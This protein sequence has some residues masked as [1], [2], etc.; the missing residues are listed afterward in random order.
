[1]TPKERIMNTSLLLLVPP[2]IVALGWAIYHFPIGKVGGGMITLAIV[3]VFFSAFLRIEIPRT[4]LHLT[5]SDAL[6]FLSMLFYGGGVAIILAM[7]EAGVSS[8][9]LSAGG[10]KARSVTKRTILANVLIAGFSTFSTAFVVETLFGHEEAILLGG[11]NTMLAYLLAVMALA[12][13]STNTFLASAYVAMRNDRK[14]LDVWN[15]QCF[16]SL[17]LFSTGALM[18][19][20]GAKAVMQTDMVQFALVAGFFGLVY[21]TF[22]RYSDDVRTV[23]SEVERSEVARAAEAD[24]HIAELNHFVEELKKTADELTESRESF[25]H[26]AYH[27]LLT[28]L[29]NRSYV[30]ELIDQLLANSG[31]Q[32]ASRFAVL[33]LN[34]DRFRT[35]NESLGY[36]TGDRV[37][38]YVASKLS[39]MARAGEIVGHFGGD[40]FTVILPGIADEAAATAF[41]EKIG[42]TLGEAIRFKGRQV[43][44]SVSIGVVFNGPAH[45]K[46]EDILRDADI[47]MYN[48]K[49]NNKGS[50]VFDKTMHSRA[51]S[52]QKIESDLRYA[53]V[54]N[55]LEMYYQPIVDLETMDLAGFEALV[56]WNHP[57]KGMVF[58]SEFIPVSEDTGL[59]IPMTLQAL[60]SSCGQIVEWQ[61]ASHLN[62][63]LTVSV[64]LSGKHF[65]DPG[66]VDQI[67]KIVKES[68]IAPETLKLEITES[69]AMEDAEKAIEKLNEI[70]KLGVKLSMDDFG[71]GYSSLSY[72]RRFPVD[73]LKIDRSFVSGMDESRQNDE[74]VQT[75]M[76]L[77]KAVKLDVVAEGIETA[78]QLGHLRRLGCE[79][80]QGYLFSRPVPAL[81]VEEMLEDRT[82]WHNLLLE[83]G[84]QA[85]R[86]ESDYSRSEFTN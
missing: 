68:G 8:M 65:A 44:T 13:F 11:N 25:R 24:A 6:V 67:K 7:L 23:S 66:L 27:Q 14:L 30:I 42:T 2:G 9:R 43:Y 76:A 45:K 12:Q 55:E 4:K 33:L 40:Q 53:I 52:R 18:A 37:I 56:R 20:L 31:G 63:Y 77:A 58:P 86:Q 41:A 35:I 83:P 59:I 60:R 19:G 5:I 73:T 34:L 51:V 62:K 3:T 46:G 85:E 49:D 81:D 79:Y 26:A 39:E 47:A 78:Q 17:T 75:I 84:F 61:N 36:Q 21:M 16:N 38:K 72:L 22:K 48:A 50:L 54:C 32:A 70:K 64:N 57:Q 10:A 82:R 80:G 74:I 28:G 69:A 15:E 29:P 1:M 71:T